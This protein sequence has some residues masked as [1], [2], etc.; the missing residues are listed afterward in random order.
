MDAVV[1]SFLQW[2]SEFNPQE[3]RLEHHCECLQECSLLY[4]KRT[5][6]QEMYNIQ[7][8]TSSVTYAYTV[9]NINKGCYS[10]SI[11]FL[12]LFFWWMGGVGVCM[13]NV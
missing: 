12:F 4:I 8:F 9:A 10:S 1:R 2:W 13:V 11:I 5:I 6:W 3:P 7:P